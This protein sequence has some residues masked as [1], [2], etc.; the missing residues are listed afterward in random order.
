ML[1]HGA[2]G[3]V[4]GHA[5][6]RPLA[7]VYSGH[8]FGVWAGQLGDGRAILLG[9]T[10]TGF[11]VQLK[12]SGL[13]PYSRMGDGRAVL[14][15]SIREFLSSE[16]IHASAVKALGT[17]GFGRS[18]VRKV[19]APDGRVDLA[20]LLTDAIGLSDG[21]VMRRAV[22][23][24]RTITVNDVDMPSERLS[25]VLWREQLLRWPSAA[26]QD[27]PVEVVR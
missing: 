10:D 1:L 21:C 9:E 26:R 3:R 8:Q 14:R 16:A 13:T 17:L 27:R 4:A 22:A 12:G 6:A 18:S 11:E 25:D 7:T 15:S 2:A 20:P 5:G 23:K 19:A 24:D